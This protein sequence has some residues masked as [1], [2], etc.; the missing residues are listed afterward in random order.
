[1]VTAEYR[2]IRNDTEGN[3]GTESMDGLGEISANIYKLIISIIFKV[4]IYYI[5]FFIFS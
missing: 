5:F 1:M 2:E 4:N 3:G